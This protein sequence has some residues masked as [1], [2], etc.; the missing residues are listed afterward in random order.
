MNVAETISIN[1]IQKTLGALNPEAAARFV[2]EHTAPAQTS[3]TNK[4]GV[5]DFCLATYAP[6]VKR[7]GSQMLLFRSMFAA[8]LIVSGSFLLTGETASTTTLL[9]TSALGIAQIVM[10]SMLV[11]GFLSRF[12]MIASTIL[13]GTIAATSIAGGVFDMTAL[14][15]CLGS[16][17]FMTMGTG[18]YSADFL[19][20]K[21]IINRAIAR[22]R[23]QRADRLTYR[24]Y[25]VHYFG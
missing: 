19:I 8:L 24:A 23:Q 22:R 12:A 20:K 4:K 9:S 13:F 17:V 6:G 18:R 3:A 10:G 5:L 21:A 16:M 14:L 25:R 7:F 2:R 15:C 1:P 11:L